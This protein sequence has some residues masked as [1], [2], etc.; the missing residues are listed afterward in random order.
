MERV[1]DWKFEQKRAGKIKE[2]GRV[3]PGMLHTCLYA[4]SGNLDKIGR[5]DSRLVGL[6]IK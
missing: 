4:R 3:A 6:E 2:K 1:P 5:G